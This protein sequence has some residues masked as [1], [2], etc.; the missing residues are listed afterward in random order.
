ME[1]ELAK[2]V[3]L[4]RTRR[5]SEYEIICRRRKVQRYRLRGMSYAEIAKELNVSEFTIK[6]DMEAIQREN[7]TRVDKFQQDQFVGESLVTFDQLQEHAW[8]EFNAA[9]G[10]SK[11]RLQALDLVR[12]I[13]ND[14]LKAL[15]ETGMVHKAPQEV[16]H[17]HTALPWSDD[18]KQQ[19]IQTMLQS[20]LKPQLGMPTPDV[21]GP[22]G[23]GRHLEGTVGDTTAEVVE[24]VASEAVEQIQNE[25][26]TKRA[27][28]NLVSH[29]LSIEEA[30]AVIE[31]E[32]QEA[33]EKNE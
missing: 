29:G 3:K 2:P 8:E 25:E 23:P 27:V 11:Q 32:K 33:S 24:P 5:S 31:K 17:T 4:K 6:R 21:D 15:Q 30:H 26:R 28:N 1:M 13:Q 12:S 7:Q 20:V 22:D 10:G 14:K 9:E 16:H 19:V 18:I